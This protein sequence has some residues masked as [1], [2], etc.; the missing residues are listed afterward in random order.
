VHANLDAELRA[1]IIAACG[2]ANARRLGKALARVEGFDLAGFVV[3][4]IAADRTGTSWSVR[5]SRP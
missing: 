1:A 3:A 2:V 5:V 4:R